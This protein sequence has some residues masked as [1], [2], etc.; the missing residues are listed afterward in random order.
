MNACPF[1]LGT[2]FHPACAQ[3][4]HGGAS[5]PKLAVTAH[6]VRAVIDTQPS[7]LSGVQPK[8]TA[9]VSPDGRELVPTSDGRFIVKP[10]WSSDLV[11]IQPSD[12]KGRRPLLRARKDL[13]QNEHLAM[14]LAR[15]VGLDVA[16]CALLEQRDGALAYVVKR[17]D[18]SDDDG[19]HSSQLDFCQLLDLPQE[20]KYEHSALR[21]AE[22]ITD[23]STNPSADLVKLFKLLVFSYWI[24]NGD[25]HL[26]NLSLI[27]R[28]DGYRLAPAYDLAC[29]YAFG[30]EK[31]ALYVSARQKDIARPHWLAFAC[32]MG[33]APDIAFQ[34]IDSLIAHHDAC[35]ELVARSPLRVEHRVAY[36]RCMTKRRRALRA[37]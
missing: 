29:G 28:G 24:G 3:A 7:K 10:E 18:R 33:L 19:P 1:C 26:K 21:C 36:R 31:L 4:F 30:D 25:L 16:H 14:C 22:V 5:L 23:F 37:R 15:L 17:F 34:V 35:L 12:L 8:F 32:S 27:D 6:T 2:A 20:Q 11:S 9:D 13:P